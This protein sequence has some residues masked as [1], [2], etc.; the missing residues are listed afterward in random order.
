MTSVADIRGLLLVGGKSSRMG[1]DKAWLNVHG[2]PQYL[3]MIRLMK[4]LVSE[5][6]LSSRPEQESQYP[7][8]DAIHVSDHPDFSGPLGGILSAF[9]QHP[10]SAW[11][12][13]ACDLLLVDELVLGQL[14][15][16]R[17]PRAD[18]TCYVSPFDGLPEPLIAIWEPSVLPKARELAG[19]GI[20]C[21]R[22]VLMNSKT[23]NLQP[24]NP[25]KLGNF[26][27][28]EELQRLISAHHR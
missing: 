8:L 10:E 24:R 23:I 13:L 14:L 20:Q 18:A 19:L 2:E 6:Y 11:L 7:T 12:V 3:H 5:V 26:N 16:A 22:K 21:P 1:T 25:E 28:P 4:P 15:E 17:D 9:Q 27:T